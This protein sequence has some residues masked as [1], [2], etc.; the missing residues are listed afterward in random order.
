MRRNTTNPHMK[1]TSP[2]I[3]FS[4]PGRVELI[5]TELPA[6][7]PDQVLIRTEFSIV[8]PGTELACLSGKEA[9]APLPFMPG[10]GSVGEVVELGESARH[11]KAGQR[12]F[13][14][15]RHG[16]FATAE[17]LAVP[18][19]DGVD[20][21]KAT[22]A[23]MAAVSITALRV[24]DAELG[25]TVAVFGLGLVG[26]F[27]AQLFTQTGCDVI[28]IDISS[29]RRDIAKKCGIAH[30][31]AP[32]DNLREEVLALTHGNLCRTVVEAT[33]VPAVA[34]HAGRLAGKNGELILLGSPRGVHMANLTD[35]LNQSHLWSEGCI[36]VKGAHEWRYPVKED[37]SILGRH[38]MEGNVACILRLIE[39]GSL[40][41]DPL[42]SHRVDPTGCQAVYDGLKNQKDVYLGVVFDWSKI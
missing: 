31:L 12:I 22:F 6:L 40:I 34:E 2:A 11:L 16:K 21:A 3:V 32:S 27:A 42:L 25:D 23:R 38:S 10:Y 30:T 26:N 19:Q 20:P 39:K 28:G 41:I 37:A 8:S 18:I 14:Y 24:S 1:R 4:A 17:V 13:T 29:E 9:W 35:F 5:E 7:K 15:G 33:G 36:T